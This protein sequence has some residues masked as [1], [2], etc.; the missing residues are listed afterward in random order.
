MSVQD[1]LGNEL[2]ILAEEILAGDFGKSNSIDLEEIK[3]RIEE[4]IAEAEYY[5]EINELEENI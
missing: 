1:N 4:I 3:I 2:F 5:A